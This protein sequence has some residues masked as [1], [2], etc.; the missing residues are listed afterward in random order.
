MYEDCQSQT[1]D[2]W[3]GVDATL[4]AAF[5]SFIS[6]V[7][8]RSPIWLR[9]PPQ[10]SPACPAS[11]SPAWPA[12]RHQGYEDEEDTLTKQEV[13]NLNTPILIQTMNLKEE[14]KN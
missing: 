8:S 9:S 2:S 1:A 13:L 14:K 11:F 5:P 10:G 12:I 7:P 4:T 6:T 3:Q